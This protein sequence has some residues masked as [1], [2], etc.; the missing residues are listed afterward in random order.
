MSAIRI[1]HVDDEPDIREIV[2]ISLGFNPD[3]DVRSC[4]SGTEA[5]T[6]AAEWSPFLIM[7]DVMISKPFDPMTLA[8]LVRS[9]LQ[10]LRLGA[11]R[12]VFMRRVKSDA[13]LLNMLRPSLLLEGDAA[14]LGRIREIAHGLAG[15]AGLFGF[16]RIGSDAAALEEAVI[17]RIDGSGSRK[18]AIQALDQL[19]A[20]LESTW[21]MP[22]SAVA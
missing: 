4:A 3:F 15:A 6:T 16:D 7:L 8:A 14:P 20:S 5:L 13:D 2:D 10:T 1:L 12:G 17:S 18:D 21:H 22:S 19:M 9:H 11:M